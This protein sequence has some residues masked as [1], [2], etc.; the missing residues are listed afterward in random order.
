MNI[1][2]CIEFLKDGA[3]GL[4]HADR[5]V[6]EMLENHVVELQEEIDELRKKQI[7]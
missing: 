3:S 1:N 2:A 6:L 5:V 4:S 7:V